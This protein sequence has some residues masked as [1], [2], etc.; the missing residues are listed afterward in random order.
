MPIE[1]CRFANG[2]LKVWCRD[3]FVECKKFMERKE[4]QIASGKEINE[5][6]DQIRTKDQAQA[7][8][9]VSL[10]RQ[11]NRVAQNG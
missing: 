5:V 4:I 7:W 1:I 10:L 8:T 6:V 9:Q 11:I 2:E 3:K